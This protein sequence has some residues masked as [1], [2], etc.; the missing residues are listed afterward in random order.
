M[1]KLTYIVVLFELTYYV[2]VF[3]LTYTVVVFELTY[4]VVVFELTYTVVVFFY[5]RL[6]PQMRVQ[7]LDMSIYILW[8]EDLLVQMT[9]LAEHLHVARCG[10][11]HVRSVF[12]T[13]SMLAVILLY[14]TYGQGSTRTHEGML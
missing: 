9:E 4:T 6:E 10:H 7:I 12:I 2:V 3:K 11:I 8:G 14:L 13:L 1:F 5:F